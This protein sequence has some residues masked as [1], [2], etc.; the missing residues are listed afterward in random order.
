MAYACRL[1]REGRTEALLVGSVDEMSAVLFHSYAR[2]RALSPRGAH[3][4]G[5]RPFDRRR[6]GRVLE[7]VRQEVDLL[8]QEKNFIFFVDDNII[9]NPAYARDLFSLL[10]DFRIKWLSQASVHIAEDDDLLRK[11]GE[12]GCYG[13]LI[14]FESLCQET[15][16]RH[17][18]TSNRVHRYRELI[19]KIHGQGIG[20]EGSFIF[21]SDDEDPSVFRQVVDFCEE[22]QIDAAVFAILTPYP[23]TRIYEQLAKENRILTRDWDL[24]DM[25]HVVFRPHKM[26]MEQLQEGHDWANQRF[27][28]YPSMLKPMLKRLWP[29]RRSQQ[30]FIPSNWG[31]RRAWRSLAKSI[32]GG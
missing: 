27:Y 11:A 24:Y 9:G 19:R 30:V 17:L 16:E 28:S 5:M 26:T 18:K 4:E 21:G 7:E 6:N 29:I 12:S 10:K 15:L 8:L 32:S 23:G 13:L 22:T 20:I 3:E 14:G 1:L 31:R 25:G 2:L